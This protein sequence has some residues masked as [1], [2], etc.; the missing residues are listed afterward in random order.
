MLFYHVKPLGLE[1][2]ETCF[3]IREIPLFQGFPSLK[4]VH[5]TIFERTAC[6]SVVHV[7]CRAPD[8]KGFRRLRTATRT[9]PSTYCPTGSLHHFLRERRQRMAAPFS[10]VTVVT[11]TL[12]QKKP[13]IIFFYSVCAK[14]FTPTGSNGTPSLSLK[15]LNIS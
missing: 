10:K 1:E 11:V 13:V 4:T 15:R 3:L 2:K 14:K 5:R 9:L 7:L 6:C 12:G 8:G